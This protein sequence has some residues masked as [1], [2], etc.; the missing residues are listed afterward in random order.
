MS[1]L[2]EH[3]V[4]SHPLDVLAFLAAAQATGERC[5]LVTVT[6]TEGGGVRARGALMAV[7]EAGRIAGH[8]SNGCVD[9]DIVVNAQDAMAAGEARKLRYGEGSPFL[10]IR[11]PCGGS[12][13]LLIV[14]DP[15]IDQIKTAL[16]ALQARNPV[17]LVLAPDGLTAETGREA[18]TGWQEDTFRVACLPKLR[19]RIAGRGAEPVALAKLALASELEVVMQSPDEICLEQSA[20]LGIPAMPLSSPAVPPPLTDDPWTAFVLMFHDHDWETDL[21][22]QAVSGEAF[23]IGALGSRRTHEIRCQSL[24]DT[25]VTDEQIARINGPVGL[26]P[27]MRDASMLAVST[28][29]EVAQAWQERHR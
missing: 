2:S 23:Y 16:E 9:A 22:K 10:D 8:V 12:L 4:Y 29:A 3:S 6:G 24:R 27:A 15:A 14:P 7:T 26:I 25:G 18:E 20:A 28:L 5:A 11:L 1:L 21:L 13:D 19:L 17:C